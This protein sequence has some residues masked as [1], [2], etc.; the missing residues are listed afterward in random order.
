MLC[1]ELEADVHVFSTL[2][3]WQVALMMQARKAQR[4]E[5]LTEYGVDYQLL[6]AAKSQHIRVIKLEGTQ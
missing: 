1:Q 3:G 4:L 5:L 6:Q 2:P